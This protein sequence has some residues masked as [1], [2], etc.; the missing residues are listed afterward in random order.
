MMT[1]MI[2]AILVAAWSLA[3][4]VD[5]D[6]GISESLARDRAARISSLRYDLAF[7]IPAARSQPVAG[8]ALIRFSLGSAAQPLVLDYLPDRA[9]IL[10][11][12]EANGVETPI[13]QVNGHIIVPKEALRAG[14]NS[15]ALDFNAGDASLN[16]SDDFLYTIFVPAR[17]HLAFPCFD[18][19]DLKARWSLA[20]D[21]PDLWQV[22]GNGA[23][24]DRETGSGRTRSLRHRNPLRVRIVPVGARERYA[25]WRSHARGAPVWR[26]PGT[27]R[28]RR[29]GR[30]RGPARGARRRRAPSPRAYG[31]EP[32]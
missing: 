23:E 8:R 20:L 16:R 26:G 21:V 3:A 4:A 1:V 30:R 7:T 9:G 13:R 6:L 5:P 24:L 29:T 18:Q 15:L 2:S 25:P 32:R 22:L 19:P 11:T 17:A 28:G 10:R 27:G 31:T 14:E 12:V